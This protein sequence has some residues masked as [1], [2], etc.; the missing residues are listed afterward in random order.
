[1]Y[2]IKRGGSAWLCATALE[3]FEVDA[4]RIRLQGEVKNFEVFKQRLFGYECINAGVIKV[5]KCSNADKCKD[6]DKYK[7]CEWRKISLETAQ[8]HKEWGK[9]VEDNGKYTF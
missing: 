8:A 7:E 9:W 6:C 3:A 2:V 4:V 1:M 5:Y